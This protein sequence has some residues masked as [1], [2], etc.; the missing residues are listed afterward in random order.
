MKWG[1]RWRKA[2]ERSGL[3]EW[4]LQ[5]GAKVWAGLEERRSWARGWAGREARRGERRHW[6]CQRLDGEQDSKEDDVQSGARGI[7]VLGERRG[8]AVCEEAEA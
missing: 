5:G 3:G 4:R 8:R 7:A 1:K 2:L 6:S